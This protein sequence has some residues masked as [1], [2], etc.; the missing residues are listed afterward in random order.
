M[1]IG[2]KCYSSKLFYQVKLLS[3]R[4]KVFQT[5]I[6][7]FFVFVF[8]SSASGKYLSTLERISS[9]LSH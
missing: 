6:T 1:L 7:S 2:T 8:F 9:V 4:V 5:Q 3:G